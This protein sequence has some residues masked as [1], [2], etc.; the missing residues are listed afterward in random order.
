MT[1]NTPDQLDPEA[2]KVGK[3]TD[4]DTKNGYFNKSFVME[5]PLDDIKLS[6]ASD[7]NSDD[8]PKP[9]IDFDDIL[10]L[11]GEFGKYQRILFLLMIPFAF[12][13]AF[14]YFAQIFITLVPEEHWCRIPELA[15]LPMDAK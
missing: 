13:V 10:P 8:L 12:F 5:S 3:D 7:N 1:V 4:G 15:D 6:T 14:V 11:I 9:Q 2:M